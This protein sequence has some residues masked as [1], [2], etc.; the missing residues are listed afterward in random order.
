[1]GKRSDKQ[2]N[3]MIKICEKNYLHILNIKMKLNLNKFHNLPHNLNN[4]SILNFTHQKHL[5]IILNKNKN[6]FMCIINY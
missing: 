6:N 1:M 3:L 5:H 4:I 2:L